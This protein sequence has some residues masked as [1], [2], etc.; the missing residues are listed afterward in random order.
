MLHSLQSRRTSRRGG[1]NCVTLASG[2]KQRLIG[3]KAGVRSIFVT[4]RAMWLSWLLQPSG[5]AVGSF[6]SGDAVQ[7]AFW[8]IQQSGR[9]ALADL[10][11]CRDRPL[12]ESL[13]P[14]KEM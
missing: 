3:Q 6:D 11:S 13:T 2:S 12:L 4:R 1:S 9:V 8:R 14:T 10:L 5:V 7:Q